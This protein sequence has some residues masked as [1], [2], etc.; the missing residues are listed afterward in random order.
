[1]ELTADQQSLLEDEP[2]FDFYW[3]T[4]R[5]NPRSV[6]FVPLA[7]LFLDHG[8]HSQAVAICDEGLA[9]HPELVSGR[10]VM[11]RALIATGALQRA[12]A[13]LHGII[14]LIPT[15]VEARH[16]LMDIQNRE[17]ALPPA[18][19]AREVTAMPWRTITMAKILANQGH[20]A[21]ALQICE[22]RLKSDPQD[23]AAEALAFRLR[24]KLHSA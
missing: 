15:H 12:R 23:A 9:H 11:A 8:F 14:A 19:E 3:R 6:V 5:Q 20:T 13:V 7:H 24:E 2:R 22:E 10:L 1:M 18:E 4:W 21:E 17:R 16:W